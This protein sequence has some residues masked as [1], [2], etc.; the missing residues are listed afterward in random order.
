M[1]RPRAF[2]WKDYAAKPDA[3]YRSAEGPARDGERP[4][5]PVRPRRLAQEPRHLGQPFEGDRSEAPAGPSTTAR[6]SA[7]SGSWPGPSGSTRR[8]PRTARPSC[9]ALDHILAAQ[10]PNGGWPQ[11]SP[12]GKGYARH[13][14]FNDNTMVNLLELLRDVARSDDFAFLDAGAAE[15]PR[16]GVRR[17]DRLHP[18]VPGPVDGKLTVWCAQHDEATLEPRPAR[19]F[20]L[21]SLSGSR[22]RRDPAAADEPGRPEPRGRPGRRRRRPLVRGVE[23]RRHPAGRGRRRQGDRAPTRTPRR[24]GPGSTRSAPTG[25]SSAAATA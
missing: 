11:T 9:R 10:Y 1:L 15:P 23:A 20:E 3:W 25:R 21:A 24:S 6:P 7:R 17:G 8:G 19:A 5:A 18:Q 16:Q 12:P 4:L 13:I 14:T 2:P 22:E